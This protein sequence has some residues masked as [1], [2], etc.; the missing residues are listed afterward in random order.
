M[1]KNKSRRNPQKLHDIFY[2]KFTSDHHLHL[3]AVNN[4]CIHKFC[5]FKTVHYSLRSVR[6]TIHRRNLMQRES[7]RERIISDKTC[8]MWSIAYLSLNLYKAQKNYS[9]IELEYFA[10]VIRKQRFWSWIELL[11]LTFMTD[12]GSLKWVISQKVLSSWLAR[13][14]H[15]RCIG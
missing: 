9:L 11:E 12:H 4:T 3:P 15:Y 5:S 13:W 1:E 10:E 14:S 8:Q 6:R 7:L 2:R